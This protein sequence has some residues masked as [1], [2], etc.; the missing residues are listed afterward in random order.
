MAEILSFSFKSGVA[1]DA[2]LGTLVVV[3][4]PDLEESGSVKS[5]KISINIGSSAVFRPIRLETGGCGGELVVVFGPL[6]VKIKKSQFLTFTFVLKIIKPV[7]QTISTK[8]VPIRVQVHFL[9][10]TANLF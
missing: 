5:S 3:E 8:F 10:H 2:G 9:L 7:K 6:T 4:G 1:A